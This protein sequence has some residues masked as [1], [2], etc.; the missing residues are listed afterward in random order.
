LLV[1]LSVWDS[2]E[3]AAE[4]S[5]TLEKTRGAGIVQLRGARVILVRGV[6]PLE[7]SYL[8]EIAGALWT[9]WD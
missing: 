3:E 4:F 1:W 2:E 5:R 9:A 7:D 6:E 8:L